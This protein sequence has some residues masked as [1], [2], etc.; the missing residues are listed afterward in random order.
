MLSGRNKYAP[1]TRSP[2]RGVGI[3]SDELQLP[4]YT[5]EEIPGG[6]KYKNQSITEP[7]ERMDHNADEGAT[8]SSKR[9]SQRSREESLSVSYKLSQNGLLA[10]L[11]LPEFHDD[12][13]QSSCS[14]R[15]VDAVFRL[16]GKHRSS[17]V[18]PDRSPER[19]MRDSF[20]SPQRALSN[21]KRDRAELLHD[22]ES[23]DCPD[24]PED[25]DYVCENTVSSCRLKRARHAAIPVPK[26]PRRNSTHPSIDVAA[27]AKVATD[28]GPLSSLSDIETISIRGFLT[29]QIF[30]SKV[31]Y[32]ITFEEKFEH[33]CSQGSV[34]APVYHDN[35]VSNQ[36]KKQAHRKGSSARRAA[37][38]RFLPEDDQLLIELKEER[39][40]PWKRIAE[41]FPNR[42]EGSLQVRY[43]TRLRGRPVGSSEPSYNMKEKSSHTGISCQAL[44]SSRESHVTD[45]QRRDAKV[46]SRQRYGPPRRRQ[47]VNRYSPL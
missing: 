18:A 14:P 16:E 25:A 6:A 21:K 29:R 13:E 35:E 47:P 31:I 39:G 30:L 28:Q 24:D 15:E 42:S 41:Y 43:C 1:E 12:E 10:R 4:T 11:P 32:S 45:H 23:S 8:P 33:S 40:L 46:L 9:K 37:G 19:E 38:T 22:D 3:E 7:Y 17:V 20:P 26:R 27:Q 36:H 5:T 44:R 34:R 2:T